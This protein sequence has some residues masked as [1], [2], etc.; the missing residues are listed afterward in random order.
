MENKANLLPPIPA[1]RYFTQEELCYLADISKEQFATWQHAYGTV[2]GYGGDRY[3]RLDVIKIRHLRNSFAP[4]IDAFSR[5]QTD[6]HGYPAMNAQ[7]ARQ[8][9]EN[10]LNSIEAVLAK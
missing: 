10:L 8:Q 7:E 2:I 6:A 4:Y 5:N 9:L 1:Q 3:T